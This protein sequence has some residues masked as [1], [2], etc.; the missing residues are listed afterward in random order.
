MTKKLRQGCLGLEGLSSL[1][2]PSGSYSIG[3]S[4]ETECEIDSTCERFSTARSLTSDQGKTRLGQLGKSFDQGLTFMT[5]LSVWGY[6]TTR[7]FFI[8]SK[9]FTDKSGQA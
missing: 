7:I 8:H 4:C 2:G 9:S 5:D 6:L 3:Q 1:W